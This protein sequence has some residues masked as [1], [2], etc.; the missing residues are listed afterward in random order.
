MSINDEGWIRGQFWLT[1]FSSSFIHLHTNVLI[2]A[3]GHTVQADCRL[4]ANSHSHARHDK[5]VLSVSHALRRCEL[6][7]RQ[8]KTVADGSLKSEH[9]NSNCPIHTATP[10]RTQTWLFCRVWCGGVNWVGPDSQA[11]AFCVWS[12]LECIGW[13]SATAGHTTQNALAVNSHRPSRHDKTAAPACRPPPPRRRPGRQL[14]LAARPPT[15]SDVVRH[16][17]RKHAVDC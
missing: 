15:R 14:R 6:N 13:R 11:G 4:K 5:T 3:F 16:A 7:S 2:D 1:T 8:L 12:V 17:K 9:V 10:D